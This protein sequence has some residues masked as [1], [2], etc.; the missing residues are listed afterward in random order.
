MFPNELHPGD[1]PPGDRDQD[2]ST[3]IGPDK[4]GDRINDPDVCRYADKRIFVLAEREPVDFS[5]ALASRVKYSSL[6]VPTAK[7]ARS[8]A[9][10]TRARSASLSPLAEPTAILIALTTEPNRS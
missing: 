8:R 2:L 7:E 3:I 1:I 5:R 10:L 9:S 4:I 6:P